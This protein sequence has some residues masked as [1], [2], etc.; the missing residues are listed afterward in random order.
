MWDKIKEMVLRL[1]GLDAESVVIGDHICA[2]CKYYYRRPTIAMSIPTCF[3]NAK[4]VVGDPV[5]G[6]KKY[7]NLIDCYDKNKTGTCSDFEK[8]VFNDQNFQ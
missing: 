4:Y 5:T 3:K 7:I 1:V 8:G 6:A 2:M